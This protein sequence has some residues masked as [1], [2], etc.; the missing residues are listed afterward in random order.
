MKGDY[1]RLGLMQ[2]DLPSAYLVYAGG[3]RLRRK[4]QLTPGGASLRITDSPSDAARE[5]LAEITILLK[6]ARF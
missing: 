5:Y 2:I 6:V 1:S 4:L 3:R